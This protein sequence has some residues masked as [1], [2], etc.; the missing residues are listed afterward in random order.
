MRRWNRGGSSLG[1]NII[2]F[3]RARHGVS[4]L[5]RD[6]I[7]DVPAQR[8]PVRVAL[9]CVPAGVEVIAGRTAR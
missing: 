6:R 1:L 4:L 8:I 5:V 7:D 2:D 3:C 9:D